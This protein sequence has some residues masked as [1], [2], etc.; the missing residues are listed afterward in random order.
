MNYLLTQLV[1]ICISSK[2]LGIVIFLRVVGGAGRLGGSLG[3]V[4]GR[5]F[6]LVYEVGGRSVFMGLFLEGEKGRKRRVVSGGSDVGNTTE[7]YVCLWKQEHVWS[8]EN[9]IGSVRLG[10]YDIYFTKIG[11]AK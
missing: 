9:K 5:R 10:K 3:G 4:L 6:N 11:P 8:L 2:H 1:I 7:R